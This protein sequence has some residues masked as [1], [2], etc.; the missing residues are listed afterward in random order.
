MNKEQKRDTLYRE[1][2]KECPLYLDNNLDD[3][4]RTYIEQ[5]LLF[6]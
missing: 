4:I 5:N 2:I 1:R 6:L 3:I